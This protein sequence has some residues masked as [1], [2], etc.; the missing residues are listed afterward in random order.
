M[1]FQPTP[2]L[3][4]PPA[5]RHYVEGPGRRCNKKMTAQ[6]LASELG[7]LIQE[8]KRKHND[9]KQVSRGGEQR[10]AGAGGV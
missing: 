5:S 8:S 4:E 1:P 7:N 3:P 2:D 10:R 6:V 9:L